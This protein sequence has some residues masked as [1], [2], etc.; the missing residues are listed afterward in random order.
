MLCALL[1]LNMVGANDRI[2]IFLIGDSTC[3]NK[4]PEESPEMGWGAILYLYFNSTVRIDNH[5][6]NGQSTKSFI[7]EGRWDNVMGRIKAGDYVF[8][9]FGHNDASL[10]HADKRTEPQGEFSENLVKYIEMTRSKGAYP[11]L[12][13]SISTRNFNAE[14]KIESTLVQYTD[15]T[16]KVAREHG[17]PL[18][19][20]ELKTALLLEDLGSEE[21]KK[22]YMWVSKSDFPYLQS[23]KQDNTHTREKGAYL[24]AGLLTEELKA[25]CITDLVLRLK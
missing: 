2:T 10:R 3:A 23:D 24:F 15:V 5:A 22:L 16:R 19:D 7:N 8:I 14:E 21:S 9:Q 13:T 1:C 17:V 6:V 12:L 18:I 20:M 4:K 11:I 25:L